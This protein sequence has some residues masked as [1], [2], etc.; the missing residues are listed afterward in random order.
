M[1]MQ[2]ILFLKSNK[3]LN[4]KGYGGL[5]NNTL[6]K[7]DLDFDYTKKENKNKLD[8]KEKSKDNLLRLYRVGNNNYNDKDRYIK[9]ISDD[10]LNLLFNKLKTRY[11]PQK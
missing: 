11:S 7:Y 1:T 9:K 8:R 10:E 3:R 5:S 6:K 2:K 4:P